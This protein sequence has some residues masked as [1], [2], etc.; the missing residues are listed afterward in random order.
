MDAAF[1]TVALAAALVS[2]SPDTVTPFANAATRALIERAIERHHAQDTAVSDYRARLQY[3]LSASASSRRWGASVPLGVEDQAMQVAWQRPN[4]LRVDVVGRRARA[5]S[6]SSELSSVFTHPWFVPRGVGDSVRIFSD[7]IPATGALHPLASGGP[8]WYR[9]ALSDS[10]RIAVPGAGALKLYAVTVQPRRVGPSLIT[11]RLWIDSASAEVVRWSFRYV[12]TALWV[13][14]GEEGRDSSSAR[15]LNGLVNRVLQIDA[16][17]EYG[18]QEGRFWLPYRQTIAGVVRIPIVSSTAISFQAVTTFRDYDVNTKRPIAFDLPAP[19]SASMDAFRDSIRA[20]RRGRPD[21]LRA[22]DNAGEWN[23]G[24]Y[25][26]HRPSDDSLARYRGWEDSLRLADATAARAQMADVDAALAGLAEDLPG[27]LTGQRPFGVAYEQLSDALRYD[28]IEGLSLGAGA[29]AQLPGRFMQLFGT[30]RYGFSDERVTGRLSI[31]RDAPAGRLALSG[32]REIADVDPFSTAHNLANTANALFVG[33]DGAD[34][35]RAQGGRVGF[36]R[37]LSVSTDLHV[38][39]MVERETSVATTAHSAV[40]D[41]LGGTGDFQP[42][43]PV[44]EGTFVG[45]GAWLKGVR[46]FGW[47][48]GGD[49]LRGAGTTSARA[50]VQAS[51]SFGGVRGATLRL[52]AGIASS[53]TLPQMAFRAGGLGT[54]RGFEYGAQRG[55]AMWAAQLDV[56]LLKGGGIRPVVFVD[57]GR[58]AAAGDLFRGPVLVGAGAGVSLYSSLLRTSLIRI[59]VSRAVTPVPTRKL[60]LDLVFQ[61]PR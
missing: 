56:S 37:I 12:G 31:V 43:P 34:Y 39:A 7:E 25:E 32:Y 21:S 24:R 61:S 35:Y 53:P 22:Y 9:Y 5:F 49:L 54:V 10:L 58:A 8:G 6:P 17:L 15:R 55:Q 41:V 52:K 27:A 16:D 51:G 45:G 11:G 3:R 26:I 14:P 47:R 18:L 19:D 60:R 48:V 13:K 2:A 29:R 4:D 59:D 38:D 50:Y 44:S 40:N 20:A 33:H 46:P 57:A 28:R 1:L 23:G 36:T 30:V 42:N